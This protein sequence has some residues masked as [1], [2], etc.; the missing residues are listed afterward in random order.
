MLGLSAYITMTVKDRTYV[1]SPEFSP[2]TDSS[3]D[4]MVVYYSRSGHSEAVARAVAQR[5]DAPIVK[6]SADYP[7]SFNGQLQAIGDAEAKAF[8]KIELD[9]FDI[10]P[11]KRLYLIAPTW[12]FR[13]APPLWTFV[14]QSDLSG[15][16][17]V[18]IL[19]GNSRYKQEEITEFSQLIASRGGQLIDAEFIRR[20]RIYWQMSRVEL[21][22]AID[23]RMDRLGTDHE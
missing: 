21:L 10:R 5:L 17:V 13:P 15:K 23:Q 4:N 3:P 11:A 7:L 18:L 20:G 8:P 1:G 2:T 6:I 14:R 22:N 19:T 16:K 12:M 9:H